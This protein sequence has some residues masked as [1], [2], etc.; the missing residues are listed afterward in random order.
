MV[1]ADIKGFFN[2]VSHEW[3]VKCVKVKIADPN[4]IRLIVRFLEAGIM[5][6]GEWEASE[7]GTSQ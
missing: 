5:E 4:I 1:D 3:L 6:D 7:V 2:N